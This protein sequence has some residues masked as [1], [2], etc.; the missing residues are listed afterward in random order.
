M[1]CDLR[2]I[3]HQQAEEIARLETLIAD[4][5][6]HPT[7]IEI[8]EPAQPEQQERLTPGTKVE[9][10]IVELRQQG[11]ALRLI[12][13]RINDEG[14]LGVK[15]GQGTRQESVKCYSGGAIGR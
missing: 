1:C 6:K 8:I 13:K 9:I 7:E 3:N 11:L 14:L 10:R 4:L 12:A 2:A 5:T 15:G